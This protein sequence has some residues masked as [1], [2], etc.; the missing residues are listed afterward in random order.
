MLV[1][2]RA[3]ALIRGFLERS[4]YDMAE[5]WT[6]GWATSSAACA[7]ISRELNAWILRNR[8]LHSCPSA[9]L[10]LRAAC[11]PTKKLSF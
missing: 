10:V 4:L 9:S 7:E 1:F 8:L 6:R 5:I 2:S 11:P 3:T